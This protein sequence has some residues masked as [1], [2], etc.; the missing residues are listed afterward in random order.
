[1]SPSWIAG[2]ELVAQLCLVIGALALLAIGGATALHRW[3]RAAERG[4]SLAAALERGAAAF[5]YG[6]VAVVVAWVAIAEIRDQYAL[7]GWTPV[8]CTVMASQLD[9][10]HVRRVAYQYEVDGRVFVGDD[11]RLGDDRSGPSLAPAERDALAPGA[12]RTCYV[13]PGD[14]SRAVASAEPVWRAR[15]GPIALLAVAMLLAASR[16]MRAG[17]RHLAIWRRLRAAAAAMP[18]AVA[19]AR[20]RNG[21]EPR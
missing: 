19:R 16:Q 8:P 21:K 12:R 13:D 5:W 7:A 18:R 4:G 17:W 20:R 11:Y 15:L 6:V 1:M 14:A 9:D 10:A 2:I 3:N